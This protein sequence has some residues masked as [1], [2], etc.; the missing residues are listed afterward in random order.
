[1]LNGIPTRREANEVIKATARNVT[2]VW[3][4][5]PVQQLRSKV[6][7]SSGKPTRAQL[8]LPQGLE[9]LLKMNIVTW[10]F[11]KTPATSIQTA[12]L[13]PCMK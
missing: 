4:P 2:K 5:D 8:S 7:P 3:V 9:G 12:K 13:K 6:L 11:E 10:E 1:M